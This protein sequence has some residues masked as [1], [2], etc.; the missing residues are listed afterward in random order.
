MAA[1]E[2]LITS[3]SAP[4]ADT[5]ASLP[6]SSPVGEL[7]YQ[8]APPWADAGPNGERLAWMPGEFGCLEAC[9]ATML[10]VDLDDVPAGPVG[11]HTKAQ[12]LE[13]RD[14][15]DGWLAGR[16][17]R[18]RDVPITRGLLNRWWIGVSVDPRPGWDHCVVCCCRRIVHDPGLRF[19]SQFPGLEVEAIARLDY[20]ILIDR[21]EER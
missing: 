16:G 12:E 10:G 17:Y 11:D 1:N 21:R 7:R 4:Q 3:P 13:A 18:R 20:A 15:L 8:P 14:R 5:H 19:G 2:A 6:V 9:I